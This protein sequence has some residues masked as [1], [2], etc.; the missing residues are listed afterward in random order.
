VYTLGLTKFFVDNDFDWYF[1]SV[2]VGVC[3]QFILGSDRGHNM[4]MYIY[5]KIF[6]EIAN[7]TP[8]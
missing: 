8:L 6:A 2:N 4:C 3:Y 1:A 7:S 5:G